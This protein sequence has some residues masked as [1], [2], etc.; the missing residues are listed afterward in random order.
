MDK[1]CRRPVSAQVANSVATVEE[2]VTKQPQNV[3]PVSVV[4]SDAVAISGPLSS[5]MF[6]VK[7]P[8]PREELKRN[9]GPPFAAVMPAV[10]SKVKSLSET[11]IPEIFQ[12]PSPRF[13]LPSI[14][15]GHI[16]T[17]FPSNFAINAS[18]EDQAAQSLDTTYLPETEAEAESPSTFLSNCT[19]PISEVDDIEELFSTALDRPSKTYEAPRLDLWSPLQTTEELFV[20]FFEHEIS[21]RLP[22]SLEFAS[23]YRNDPCFRSAVLTL[24]TA[25]ALRH[26]EILSQHGGEIARIEHAQRSQTYYQT[27]LNEIRE[28]IYDL[29]GPHV[30]QGDSLA[31]ASLMLA[32]HEMQAGTALGIRHQ[33]YNLDLIA[34]KIQPKLA[35]NPE[36]LK[37]WRLL[38][39]DK[40]FIS[41][42]TRTGASDVDGHEHFHSLNPELT[43][44]DILI[45]V[46]KL[47]A[48]YAV[49][50]A[51]KHSVAQEAS[52]SGARQSGQWLRT[53]LNRDCDNRQARQ[54]DYHRNNLTKD[55]I[56]KLCDEITA[57]LDKWYATLSTD[58]VP[59]IRAGSSE[60]FI[61][62]PPFEPVPTYR[63]TDPAKALN[64]L[65]YLLS[66]M[67]CAY[68]RSL[69][70]PSATASITQMWGTMI[71]GLACGSRLS[72]LKFTTI[73]IEEVLL[74]TALLSEGTQTTTLL[75]EYLVPRL[76]DGEAMEADKLPWINVK[77]SLQI[78][79]RERYRGKAIRFMVDG[80]HENSTEEDTRKTRAVAVFGDFNGKGHFRDIYQ[81]C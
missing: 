77:S 76:M 46:W 36:L 34:S 43:I 62:V 26:K 56:M 21:T 51:F 24:S 67:T 37:A 11:P 52:E 69:F 53:V 15:T 50:A 40:R 28:R 17:G 30:P 75:L 6:P 59:S 68:L 57:Q 81:L 54:D 19:S 8:T 44:R 71:L 64:Y 10:G 65:L 18:I 23:W 42:P 74:M 9:D 72:R 22:V 29:D 27:A 4:G 79:Q 78:I 49:E 39:C 32:Y 14:V 1:L 7:P 16:T 60:D 2:S 20:S 13:D 38:R 12:A 66:R 31:G 45:R 47:H 35:S 63:I 61:T 41:M 3:Q 80:L 58:E 73:S 5:R 33:A 25:T 55:H 48:R 70:D